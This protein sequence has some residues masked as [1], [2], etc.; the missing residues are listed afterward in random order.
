VD[1]IA[2]LTLDSL[3]DVS[4]AALSI[5]EKDTSLGNT[6]K[7]NR[8]SLKRSLSLVTRISLLNIVTASRNDLTSILRTTRT[9]ITLKIS[10]K[11]PSKP[12]QLI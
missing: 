7:K 12:L 3:Q 6:P 9:T 11:E 1:A 5:I 2:T 10:L 4:H 8:T